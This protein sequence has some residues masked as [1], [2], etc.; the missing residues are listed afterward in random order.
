MISF[1]KKAGR[2]LFNFDTAFKDIKK[3]KGIR[4]AFWFLLVFLLFTQLFMVVYYAKVSLPRF[5]LDVELD[6]SVFLVLYVV[7]TVLLVGF[8]FFRPWITTLFVR[9]FRVGARFQDTYKVMVY[10]ASP[11]YMVTPFFVG[12]MLGLALFPKVGWWIVL[13]IGLGLVSLAGL[14][15]EW[16]LRVKGMARIHRIGYFYAVLCLYVFPL[17]L[18]IVVE[19]V[20]ILLVGGVYLFAR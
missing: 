17:V 1:L 14:V 7:T 3:E 6:V 19:V 12:F 9:L 5:G 4:S 16:V 13:L 18:L 15:F 10:G 11:G 20:L 2:I 8:A